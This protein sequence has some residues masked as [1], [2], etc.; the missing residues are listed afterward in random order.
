MRS[1]SR[2]RPNTA[3]G[4]FVHLDLVPTETDTSK[5]D[6]K[7]SPLFGFPKSFQNSQIGF[8]AFTIEEL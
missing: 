8:S 5:S 7:I 6:L 3:L 1:I 4:I 2:K